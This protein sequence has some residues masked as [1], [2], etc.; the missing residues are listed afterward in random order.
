MPRPPL[1]PAPR[2]AVPPAPR[3]P[4]RRHPVTLTLSPGERAALEAV[5]ERHGAPL[6]R[7]VGALGR[8][9][10]RTSL[11]IPPVDF[12]EVDEDAENSRTK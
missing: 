3:W 5:A 8:Y 11:S 12:G 10:E 9:A 1:S 7:L 6:A 2:A 4:R